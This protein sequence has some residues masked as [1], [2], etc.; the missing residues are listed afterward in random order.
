MNVLD[1][2]VTLPNAASTGTARFQ[3]HASKPS[4]ATAKYL[5]PNGDIHVPY[6]SGALTI[7]FH[8]KTGSVNLPGHGDVPIRFDLGLQGPGHGKRVLKIWEGTDKATTK[9]PTPFSGPALS[10]QNTTISASFD[11]QTPDSS[12]HYRL[13]V[14]A[15]THN[16]IVV[17]EVDPIIKNGGTEKNIFDWLSAHPYIGIGI[18]IVL[19]V[20]VAFFV[21]R[22]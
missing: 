17:I 9:W 16:S 1:V 4:E 18:G 22:S 12:Y 19:V 13:A 8:L 20:I 15:R 3:F 14:G 6:G 7:R 10:N 11:N 21:R 2:D 5:Q